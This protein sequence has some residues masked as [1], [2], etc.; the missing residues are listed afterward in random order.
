MVKFLELIKAETIKPVSQACSHPLR[1]LLLSLNHIDQTKLR[2]ILKTKRHLNLPL[3]LKLALL[4]ADNL[5][6]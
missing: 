1:S 2:L 4:A 3:Y 6:P 5:E